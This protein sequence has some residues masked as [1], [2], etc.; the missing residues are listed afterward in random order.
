MFL[1]TWFYGWVQPAEIGRPLIDTDNK[2]NTILYYKKQINF[3]N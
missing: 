1:K 2:S 3:E